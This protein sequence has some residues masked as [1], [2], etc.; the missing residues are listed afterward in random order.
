MNELRQ[1]PKAALL[2]EVGDGAEGP[3]ARAG[4]R[5]RPCMPE[6]KQASEFDPKA[7]FRQHLDAFAASLPEPE[8]ILFRQLL[9]LAATALDVENDEVAG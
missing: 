4:S 8:Q 9:A 3:E 2:K 6:Q 1:R 7:S 5:W